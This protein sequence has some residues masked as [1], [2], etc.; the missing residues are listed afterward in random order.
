MSLKPRAFEIASSVQRNR[1]QDILSR[2][3]STYR[4]QVKNGFSRAML[5]FSERSNAVIERKQR[6]K[7]NRIEWKDEPRSVPRIVD[8]LTLRARYNDDKNL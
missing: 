7:K 3:K 8:T 1:H 6:K 2:N 5:S 4:Y